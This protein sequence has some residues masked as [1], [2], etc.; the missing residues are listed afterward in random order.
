MPEIAAFARERKLVSMSD[1]SIYTAAGGL[2]SYGP[3]LASVRELTVGYVDKIL[4]GAKPADLPVQ[5]TLKWNMVLNAKTAHAIG[6]KPPA[7]FKLQV[8]HEIE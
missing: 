3:D 2:R 8:T 7:A 1:S 6:F 5:Q 4:R